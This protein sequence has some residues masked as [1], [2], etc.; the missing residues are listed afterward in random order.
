[1]HI[2]GVSELCLLYELTVFSLAKANLS[3]R[4]RDIDT[5]SLGQK[6][7]DSLLPTIDYYRRDAIGP[8]P[9]SKVKA[10]TW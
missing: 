8:L 7:A 2:N 4:Y 5:Q 6:K 9:V 3:E 10:I 1:M